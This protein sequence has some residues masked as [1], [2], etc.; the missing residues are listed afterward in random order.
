MKKSL[1]IQKARVTLA[2]VARS[3]GVSLSTVS[4]VL[5]DKPLARNLAAAT[6]HRIRNIAEQLNYR[7]DAAARS[8]RSRRSQ[9]IGVMV[10][11]IADPYCTLILQGIQETLGETALLPI[12]MDAH[13]QRQ[14]F[15]RYLG[16]AV[17]HHVEGLIVVA[18]WLFVDIEALR[19]FERNG[20]PTAIV[21][22]EFPSPSIS[23]VLVDNEAGGRLAF[24][25]LHGL[26]HTHIAVV[27]GPERLQD[28]ERRWLGIE[29]AAKTAGVKLDRRLVLQLP[30]TADPVLGYA[31][32]YQAA[33]RL[34]ASGRDFT[35]VLAFDDLTAFGVIRGLH[36]AGLNVPRDVSVVGFD[37]IPQAILTMPSL[38]TV[39]QHMRE[40]GRSAAAHVLESIQ[41]KTASKPPRSFILL[42]PPTLIARESTASARDAATHDPSTRVNRGQGRKR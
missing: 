18:N 38:T 28:S 4:L 40:M 24:E 3:A 12:I 22:R 1:P 9:L 15:A 19:R 39:S 31:G 41:S 7:P 17:E 25:H 27:R 34:I 8:L 21:G 37:D 23:S 11:D 10:F 30:E 35:G 2:D 13:N 33:K 16:M 14:Q 26:G 42:H 32:G 5:N 29:A 20:I 36:E 6:R